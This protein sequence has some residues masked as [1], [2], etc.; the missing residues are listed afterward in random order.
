MRGFCCRMRLYSFAAWS[1]LPCSSSASALSSVRLVRVGRGRRQF[2]R[3]R[4]GEIGVGVHRHVEDVGIVRELTV[5][6]A[7]KVH[8]RI[9]LV[10][11]HGAAHAS[12]THLA[13][14][15]LVPR[16]GR[17][18][19]QDGDGLLAVA[20]IGQLQPLLSSGRQGRLPALPWSERQ[21]LPQR[22]APRSSGNQSRGKGSRHK[23]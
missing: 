19:P 22:S 3:R 2:L 21:E 14:E 17:G 18:L 10:L 4:R 1:H 23:K 12:E 13:L 7:Q 15:L 6:E 8:R 5:Q 11:G 20:V 16:L 9:R